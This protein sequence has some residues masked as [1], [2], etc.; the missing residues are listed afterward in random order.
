MKNA[1]IVFTLV[2]FALVIL[3][4]SNRFYCSKIENRIY[5]WLNLCTSMKLPLFI[6]N[7]GRIKN[8]NM[9]KNTY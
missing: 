5:K 2:V 3:K 4:D 8:E 7:H 9:S 1:L 6:T